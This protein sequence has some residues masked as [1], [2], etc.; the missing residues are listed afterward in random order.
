MRS[1]PIAYI[2]IALAVNA[3]AAPTPTIYRRDGGAGSDSTTGTSG[4][5]TGGTITNSGA[6]VFNGED[7]GTHLLA[8]L[9]IINSHTSLIQVT[10]EMAERLALVLHR[11]ET[12]A[13]APGDGSMATPAVL[14]GLH[15]QETQDLPVA[16]ASP[17]TRGH[18]G[19]PSALA[20]PV[21]AA[22]P[23]QAAH[24]AATAGAAVGVSSAMVAAEQQGPCSLATP[25][26]RSVA[27]L[28]P[29]RRAWLATTVVQGTR[30]TVAPARAGVLLVA[31]EAATEFVR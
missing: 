1:S 15:S 4:T 9:S 8:S 20:M 26:L 3:L 7:S 6:V 13:P 2:V 11:P 24:R 30:A 10:P 22:R 16:A 25:D 27:P 28:L 17:P 21:A 18:R 31:R 12:A 23:A 14:E 19:T 29:P 5:V